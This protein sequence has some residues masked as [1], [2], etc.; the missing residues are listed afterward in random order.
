MP[1]NDCKKFFIKCNIFLFLQ[2]AMSRI[3]E[4]TDESRN[5]NS[6]SG[7][8]VLFQ[9]FPQYWGWYGSNSSSKTPSGNDKHKLRSDDFAPIDQIIYFTICFLAENEALVP[10]T[11]SDNTLDAELLKALANV[12]DDRQNC[13]VVAQFEFTLEEGTFSICMGESYSKR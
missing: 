10:S 8:G 9:W 7:Y 12:R 5:T 1:V 4:K 2:V 13:H 6:G 3:P 11:T